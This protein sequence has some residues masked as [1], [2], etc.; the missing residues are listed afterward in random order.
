MWADVFDKRCRES[1]EYEFDWPTTW[2]TLDQAEKN[3]REKLS[4]NTDQADRFNEWKREW[5]LLDFESLEPMIKVLEY[6]KDKYS[7]DNWKKWFP[8]EQLLNS[9][10][11]HVVEVYK[12]NELDE[13]SKQHHMAHIMCNAMMY[14]YHTNNNTFK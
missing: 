9:L 5:H 6:W 13:E 7:A 14:I 12:G 11:R 4:P 8:K 10:Q 3:L 2:L 1:P